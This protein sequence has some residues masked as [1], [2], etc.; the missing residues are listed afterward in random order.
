MRAKVGQ[1][2]IAYSELMNLVEKTRQEVGCI[3]YDLH[4]GLE[5]R[6]DFVFYENWQ[7]ME[8]LEAHWATPHLVRL[9]SIAGEL[10]VAPADVK[11]FSMVSAPLTSDCV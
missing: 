8:L 9:K 5:D 6:S 7:S 10:F 3:N 1:E 4:R 11:L 2:E